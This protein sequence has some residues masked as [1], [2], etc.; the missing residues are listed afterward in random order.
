MEAGV[1]ETVMLMHSPSLC[2][3]ELL[4]VC[5]CVCVCVCLEH[6][7]RA[8]HARTARVLLGAC[9]VWLGCDCAR[10]LLHGVAI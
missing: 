3:H 2:I 6:A 1:R 10:I 9:A 4:R 5:V 8:S 7:H